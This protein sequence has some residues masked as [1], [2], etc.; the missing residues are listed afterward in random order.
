MD[1]SSEAFCPREQGQ[2]HRD[3]GACLT[4]HDMPTTEHCHLTKLMSYW[5]RYETC[6]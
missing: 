2:V 5:E 4:R 6:L 1:M 3:V